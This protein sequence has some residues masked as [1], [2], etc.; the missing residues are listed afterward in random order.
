V[1]LVAELGE[2]DVLRVFSRP[3]AFSPKSSVSARYE[4]PNA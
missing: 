4:T 3:A 1:E 2:I